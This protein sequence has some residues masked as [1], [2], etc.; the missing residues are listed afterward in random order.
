MQSCVVWSCRGVLWRPVPSRLVSCGR[1]LPLS[2]VTWRFAASSRHVA[3]CRFVASRGVLPLRCVTWRLPLRP[4][5][6]YLTSLA[7][8]R[9]RGLRSAGT[10]HRPYIPQHRQSVKPV[11]WPLETLTF[12]CRRA[13]ALGRHRR[14]GTPRDLGK[15]PSTVVRCMNCKMHDYNHNPRCAHGLSKIRTIPFFLRFGVC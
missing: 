6:F 7:A 2:R 1:V 15:N 4:V 3:F 5:P 8:C 14:S 9:S 13:G 11:R 12:D 10:T